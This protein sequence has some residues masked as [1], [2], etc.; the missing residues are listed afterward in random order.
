MKQFLIPYMRQWLA[1]LII[2]L[3]LI[4]GYLSHSPSNYS[5][6]EA[7][8]S[9]RQE[10]KELLES[11]KNDFLKR[12]KVLENGLIGL[13]FPYMGSSIQ[14]RLEAASLEQAKK[15]LDFCVL[16]LFKLE[17]QLSSWK[18]FSEISRLNQNSGIRETSLSTETFEILEISKDLHQQ[19]DGMFDITIGPLWDLWPFRNPAKSIPDQAE[20]MQNLALVGSQLLELNKAS[21]TAYL[22]KQGMRVNLGGIGK[23][24][25]ALKTVQWLSGFGIESSAV[26]AG[27]DLYLG[28][29][30]KGGKWKVHIENPQDPLRALVSFYGSELA[31]ATS[32]NSQRFIVHEGKKYGHILDPHTGNP[33]DSFLSVTVVCQDPVQADAFATA[34]FAMNRQKAMQWLELRKSLLSWETTLLL[35]SRPMP[36]WISSPSAVRWAL[37]I[38]RDRFVFLFSAFTARSRSLNRSLK[39]SSKRLK[40]WW[41]VIRSMSA[42]MSAR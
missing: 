33:G 29:A 36:T 27:G 18:P 1:F 20:I 2:V 26:S 31:V 5:N 11:R 4:S 13:D 7:D 16:Q 40:Q 28:K 6:K 39:N 41:S 19:T 22:P 12:M 24:Y 15:A 3:S 25:A 9:P 37:S 21:Q 34:L 30:H 14:I 17:N 42:W 35:W 8:S 38:T 10:S 23:G 32:G